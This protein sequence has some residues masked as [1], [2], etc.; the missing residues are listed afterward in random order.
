MVD[1]PKDPR[2]MAGY[3]ETIS[4]DDYMGIMDE[5]ARMQ[6]G[7]PESTMLRAQREIGGGLFPHSLEHVGDLTHRINESGGAFGTEFVRPK[8]KSQLDALERPYGYEREMMEQVESNKRYMEERGRPSVDIDRIR[9]I[10]S[11]YAKEHEAIPIINAPTAF[12][13]Q[14]AIN[15]GNMQFNNV[16]G[17]LRSLKRLTD[18]EDAYKES[19]SRRG[20]IRFL[21]AE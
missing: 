9:E 18:N 8:V 20:A 1:L 19:I 15:L 16:V 4:D 10:G 21:R 12:G 3:F 14:A 13:R 2:D 11:E 6:R 17:S 7:R 5:V